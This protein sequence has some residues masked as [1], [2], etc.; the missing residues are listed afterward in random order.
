MEMIAGEEIL[1]SALKSLRRN[2]SSSMLTTL[3]IAIGVGA[4]IAAFAI[5]QGANKMID[6]QIAAFGSNFVM[7]FS[8]RSG[9]SSQGSIRYITID[10][11]NAIE[12]NVSGIDALAPLVNASVTVIYGN[13]N[14]AT[15]LVGSNANYSYVQ[16]RE[17]ARGRDI[18]DSDVRQGTKVAVIGQTV[19]EKLFGEENPLG[20][21]IRVNKIP[22]TI[23]GVYEKKG[24]SYMGGDQDDIILIPITTAQKRIVRIRGSVNR[25]QSI[26]I[27]GVSMEALEYIQAETEALLRE[28]H[29]IGKGEPDDFSVRNISQMLEARKKTT[30]IMSLLLAAIAGISL[31]VGG[32][33]IMNI[34]LVSVTERTKEIG[35]RMAVG[36][37]VSDIRT[38]FLLEAVV[39]SNIGGF[40]GILCGIAAGFGLAALTQAPPIFSIASILL[41]WIFS[42]MVGVGFGYYPAYKASL[43]NPIDALKYE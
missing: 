19:A 7:V 12:Q 18:Y 42:G 38:Q 37:K 24:Q 33:G 34:M 3:G 25:I 43:L 2:K 9:S 27:Q 32:I 10:D 29:K 26:Y 36:A 23:V 1:R 8:Q 21:S 39:L 11:A 17:I 40:L 35:V 20:R 6:E 41:A 22:F 15:S 13:T 28:L 14:W 4:V 30:S 5:G 31:V 16:S